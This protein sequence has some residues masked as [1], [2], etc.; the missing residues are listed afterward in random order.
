MISK[1]TIL[2]CNAVNSDLTYLPLR[3]LLCTKVNNLF[4]SIFTTWVVVLEQL[5]TTHANL[6]Q[7]NLS[8]S[9]NY[10]LNANLETDINCRRLGRSEELERTAIAREHQRLSTFISVLD[11][12]GLLFL[13]D[14]RIEE[15]HIEYIPCAQFL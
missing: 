2:L 3:K 15:K 13:I 4:N 1:Y 11:S 12:T 5:E 10:T 9:Y 7:Y 8:L 14:F 6:E